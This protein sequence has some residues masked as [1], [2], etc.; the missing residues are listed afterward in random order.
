[1]L[2]VKAIVVGWSTLAI[3]RV[4]EGSV[5]ALTL[6]LP[7]FVPERA[8]RTSPISV[9]VTDLGSAEESSQSQERLPPLQ[10]TPPCVTLSLLVAYNVLERE[11]IVVGQT[12]STRPPAGISAE[13]KPK[14]MESCAYWPQ[15]KFEGD[16]E[17][18]S[19]LPTAVYFML[20]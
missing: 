5:N 19:K 2:A 3:R 14:V 20:P 11:F 16:A 7:G 13:L 8:V 1:V 17:K 6:K 4:L 9:R 10:G 18:V 12:S 15:Y